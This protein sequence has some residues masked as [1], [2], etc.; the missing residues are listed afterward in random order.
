MKKLS[1][2][3]L[4]SSHVYLA[5]DNSNP[6][7]YIAKFVICDFGR[8][9][10]GYALSRDGID[11][12]ISTLKNKPLVGKIKMRID[13]S[14]DFT[15]HNMKLIEMV[16]EDGNTYKDAEFDTD[17]FGSFFD[18]AIETINDK[19]YIVA[20]C[21]IW[22]RFH[23]ACS[24]II[25]RIRDGTLHTS[26][27]IAVEESHQGII[28]GFMTTIVDA[29]R[30]I[31]HCLLGKQ[32]EPAYDSSGLLAI[33]ST[34]YDTEISEALSEDILSQ[35]LNKNDEN[36]ED[37]TGMA[38]Q[39]NSTVAENVTDV[40]TPTDTDSTTTDTA[41]ANM[42]EQI[43]TSDNVGTNEPSVEIAQL[44]EWDL[45]S[46]IAKACADKIDKSWC[47]IAYHFPVEK[48]V[49]CE[50]SGAPS[51][52]DYARFTYEVSNDVVTVSDVE[53]VKLTVSIAEVNT[54]ISELE[55]EIQTVKAELDIK[56]DAITKA[57]ETIQSLNTQ[58]SELTPYKEQVEVAERKKIEEQITAEKEALK[59]KL[60]KGN[61]FTEA[62]I[63]EKKIQDLIE[64]RDVSA[65]NGLIADK[66]VASFD[67]DHK[68]ENAETV[69]TAET[70]VTATANLESEDTET[71]V[72]S[73]MSK[74]LSN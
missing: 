35:G 20:S 44:T 28:D 41:N 56:N 12:W 33:A 59:N 57:S 42:A 27:E 65:I 37:N 64:A 69:S 4:Y 5:E 55:K 29:G 52:L 47:Y 71:D 51:E 34:D 46:K 2:I 7:S 53:Y 8:N 16:D 31:G 32:V 15:G 38:K 50:Y 1:N 58:I 40:K 3:T 21:E 26:W 9:K 6:D 19:E 70:V 66:F 49:W 11:S 18:I 60:L 62:E 63:A 61:L 72:R 68:N 67:V 45:R 54:K 36:K 13:G 22:K 39:N 25:N 74:I 43:N 73:F 14:Y 24:I 17:A 23:K 10:N 48:E 30:F